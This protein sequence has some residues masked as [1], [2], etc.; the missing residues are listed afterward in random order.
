MD[1]QVYG[2]VSTKVRK[3][4]DALLDALLAA[5]PFVE[6]YDGPDLAKV[7]DAARLMGKIKKAIRQTGILV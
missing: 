5:L 3:Q 1:Q 4:R 2:C 6:D 7:C